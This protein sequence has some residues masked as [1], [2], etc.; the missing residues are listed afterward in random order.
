[1]GEAG[2]VSI[3]LDVIVEVSGLSTRSK[4]DLITN[5]AILLKPIISPVTKAS[6]SFG[7]PVID[8]R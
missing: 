1:M 4:Y 2:A 5:M 8:A 3:G 7:L 6:I